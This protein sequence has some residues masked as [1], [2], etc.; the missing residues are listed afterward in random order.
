MA[1]K[2]I[3]SNNKTIIKTPFPEMEAKY[4]QIVDIKSGNNDVILSFLQLLP[5]VTND[6]GPEQLEVKCVS[7]II[8]SLE[9][10]K[11][12]VDYVNQVDSFL[13]ELAKNGE[14][15]EK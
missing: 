15:N 4:S 14:T 1:Q 9:K 10:F 7:R 12:F 3:K 5:P 2:K 11:S 6:D 13:T 8:M